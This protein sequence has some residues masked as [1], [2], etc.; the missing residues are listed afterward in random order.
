MGQQVVQLHDR[1]DDDDDDDDDE[2]SPSPCC[3]GGVKKNP[4]LG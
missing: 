2:L 1:Y 3:D 4:C